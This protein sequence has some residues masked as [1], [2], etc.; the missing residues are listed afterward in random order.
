MNNPTLSRWLGEEGIFFH[1]LDL[2]HFGQ[3]YQTAE[4]AAS[5]F[6]QLG[7]KQL[8]EAE[9]SALKE[10]LVYLDHSPALGTWVCVAARRCSNTEFVVK[11]KRLMAEFPSVVLEPWEC[12]RL[13]AINKRRQ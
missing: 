13:E 5:V 4:E 7:G 6:H 12:Q 3:L 9:M 11:A 8:S 1:V 10:G 2:G